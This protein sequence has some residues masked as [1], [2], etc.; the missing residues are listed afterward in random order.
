MNKYI[1]ASASLAG[2]AYGWGINGHMFAAKMAQ[3][4]LEDL[5]PDA[6]EAAQESLQVLCDYDGVYWCTTQ[7]NHPFVECATFAD[8]FKYGGASW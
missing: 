2:G 8:E 3:D 4:Q 1:I 7:N 5:A 6:F